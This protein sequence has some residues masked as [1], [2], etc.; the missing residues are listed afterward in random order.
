M[1]REGVVLLLLLLVVMVMVVVLSLVV[2]L[3]LLVVVVVVLLMV[4]VVVVVLFKTL[5]FDCLTC[6]MFCVLSIA[7]DGCRCVVVELQWL[8]GGCFRICS[9][10]GRIGPA[11]NVVRSG[12]GGR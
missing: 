7:M 5:I 3:L 9:V 11:N 6:V 4:V 2:L 1:V 10:G 8:I 12:R